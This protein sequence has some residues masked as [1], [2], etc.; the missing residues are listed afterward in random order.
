MDRR[1]FLQGCGLGVVV[2]AVPAASYAV[3]K[4]KDSSVVGPI[5]LERVCDH[6]KS[7]MS[8]EEWMYTKAHSNYLGCGTRFRW[9]L[10]MSC[11]CPNCG[12]TYIY[13]HED[14]KNKRFF[15]RAHS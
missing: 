10:G 6:E 15:V 11:I 9:Y 5:L 1:N 7:R 12:W 14:L 4:S 13:T 3:A 8:E 2:A